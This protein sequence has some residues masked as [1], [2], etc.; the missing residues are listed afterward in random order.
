[1]NAL[2]TIQPGSYRLGTAQVW[3]TDR[4]DGLAI[5]ALMSLVPASGG[6]SALDAANGTVGGL[7]S[8][9]TVAVTGTALVVLDRVRGVLRSFDPIANV[10]RDVNH[11]GTLSSGAGYFTSG[12]SI[13]ATATSIAIADPSLPHLIVIDADTFAIVALVPVPDGPISVAARAGRFVVLDKCGSIIRTTPTF[14]HVER[15]D[16][17]R[18]E[19]VQL[20]RV[21]VDRNGTVYVLDASAPALLPVA[22]VARPPIVTASVVADLFDT[23][24]IKVDGQGRFRVPAR[25]R[26]SE[27]DDVLFDP[28]GEPAASATTS[29]TPEFVGSGRWR[30][31][32]LDAKRPGARWHRIVAAATLPPGTA[33]RIRTMSSDVRASGADSV[34]ALGRWSVAH[35]VIA[36]AQPRAVPDEE[37]IELAVLSER[38]RFLTVELELSGDGWETPR[39]RELLVEPNRPEIERF[40]PS[41][42]RADPT[43]TEFLHR[44]LAMFERE[45]DHF[46]QLLKSLPAVFSPTSTPDSWINVLAAELGL[47]MERRWSAGQRRRHLEK[48]PRLYPLRGTPAALVATLRSHL[49][50]A[51]ERDLPPDVPAVVEGY[52]ERN[53]S[54][55]EERPR[56]GA[57][58]FR[59]SIRLTTPSNPVTDVFSAFAHRFRVVVP[60]PLVPNAD[61]LDAFERAIQSEKPAHV[62]HDIVVVEPRTVIGVQHCLGVSTY[63]GPSGTTVHLA[64]ADDKQQKGRVGVRPRLGHSSSSRRSMVA[65]DHGA[66]ADG[67]TIL[68]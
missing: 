3:P 16:A 37:L 57:P 6:S 1:M 64:H 48:A 62:A 61:A 5:G 52:T 44:F 26:V 49:E 25:L 42:F 59:D 10:F 63:L 20:T 35:T 24:P 14:V 31:T 17:H 32:P 28:T 8:P 40:L 67:E 51:N 46:D 33:F 60:R 39:I 13:A 58:G 65:T 34:Q 27:R 53:A 9:P 11:L 15:V 45:F 56:L 2:S 23:P 30:S 68:L 50:A 29:T 38:G 4:S 22:R 55:V 47:P 7:V 19:D 18:I 66:R 43:A 12:A 41:T 54:A 21:V 36:K